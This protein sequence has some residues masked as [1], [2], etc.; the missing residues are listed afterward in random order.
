MVLNQAA[1][2]REAETNAVRSGGEKR[3]EDAL[4]LVWRHAATG[5]AD[6]KFKPL[7]PAQFC[8]L[9][10]HQATGNRQRAALRHGL[11]SVGEEIEQH[12]LHL[13]NIRLYRRNIA[14]E[15]PHRYPGVGALP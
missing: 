12:L 11:D 1:R 4:P 9:P 5:I 15:A 7:A 13:G 2:D 10:G 6:G 8:T 3:L 14:V